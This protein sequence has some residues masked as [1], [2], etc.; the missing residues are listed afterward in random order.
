MS[1]SKVHCFHTARPAA[2][3]TFKWRVIFNERREQVCGLQRQLGKRWSQKA[4]GEWRSIARQSQASA[5]VVSGLTI[6]EKGHI[7]L[8]H[9]FFHCGV[10]L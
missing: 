7:K 4:R 6:S 5:K 9:F 3:V 10:S 8:A 1:T 2:K